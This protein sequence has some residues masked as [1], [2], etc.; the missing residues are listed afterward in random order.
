ML[1]RLKYRFI[2]VNM[3]IFS[4][5][6]FGTL[7]GIFVL[8]YNSEIK[9]SE[10]IMNNIIKNLSNDI[11]E[12]NIHQIKYNPNEEV[13]ET[14]IFEFNKENIKKEEVNDFEFDY[15][16]NCEN[17]EPPKHDDTPQYNPYFNPYTYNYYQYPF[18]SHEPQPPQTE[19]TIK[20]PERETNPPILTTISERPT[21]L[22]TKTEPKRKETERTKPTPPTVQTEPTHQ[23]PATQAPAIV[24]PPNIKTETTQVPVIEPTEA[25][26]TDLTTS[27]IIE[28]TLIFAP[29][30]T[31]EVTTSITNKITTKKD[32]PKEPMQKFDGNTIRA[33]IL[34]KLDDDKKVFDVLFNYYDD[35]PVEKEE[36][37]KI[38]NQIMNNKDDTGKIKIDEFS[39]RYKMARN[40]MTNGFD[41]IF[42]D[43]SI[44][45]STLNRLLF[46]FIIIAGIGL[47]IVFIFSVFLANW[48]IKP[49]ENAWNKQKQFIADAS[50]E[51]KTPLTVISTNTDVVLSNPLDSVKNQEKWLTYIKSETFRMSKLVNELLYIAKSDSNEVKMVMNEFD[52]SNTISSVCLVFEPMI[53]ESGKTL[54][55]DLTK[56]INFFGDEDRIKQLISILLDNAIKHSTVNSMITV[57]LFKNSQNKIKLCVSNNTEFISKEQLNRLF[58]RFYRTDDSRNRNTGGNGLGLNIAQS[59]VH[60]HSGN[61][62]AQTQNSTISFNVT[63]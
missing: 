37:V 54:K 46:A 48:A 21:A 23:H 51:L 45:L 59:I 41:L 42:L 63:F 58:D 62:I 56:K 31:L 33:N 22:T 17:Q 8:M 15:N 13:L 1:K 27:E 6:L 39:Y 57:S 7:S 2:L 11:I 3:I 29:V 5:V 47:I 52:L 55:M 34:V 26:V 38:A 14:S 28:S 44:E 35:K 24:P 30:E 61:I 19:V 20:I 53:F 10:E 9:M 4:L 60:N 49:V 25:V 40:T 50:H 12:Q 16:K 32:P 36:I 43:R 18:P